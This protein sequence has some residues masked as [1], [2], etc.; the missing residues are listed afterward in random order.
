MGL[1]G[2]YEL[3]ALKVF[4]Q[5]L[6]GLD[7]HLQIVGTMGVDQLTDLLALV[8][9]FLYEAAIVAEEMLGEELVELVGWGLL[10]LINLHGELLAEHEGVREGAFDWAEPAQH[11]R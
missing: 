8:R 10:V 7:A 3:I 2:I 5:L 9:A 4:L 11:H 6:H 1:A